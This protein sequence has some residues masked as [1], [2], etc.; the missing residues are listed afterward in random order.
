MQQHICKNCEHVF[1]GNF[2]NHCGQKSKT[3]RLNFHYL[4]DEIKYTFLHI[5]KGLLYSVK[6]LIVRPGDTVREFLEGKRVSHYKPILLLVVLAGISGLLAHYFLDFSEI[7]KNSQ[8][9]VV[10][11]D[12]Q[13]VDF[14]KKIMDWIMEHYSLYEI[15][16]LPLVSL[17]SYLA[18]K[19]YGYNYIENIIINSFAAS[20]RL[21]YGLLIFPLEYFAIKFNFF[22]L[23]S[24]LSLVF[25]I[26]ISIWFYIK[27][28]KD[29]V[30]GDVIVRLLLFGF[31]AF[32]FFSILVAFVFFYAMYNSQLGVH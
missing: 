6:Q 29:K 31:L 18:F 19:K 27:L 14:T 7:Y 9:I 16:Q 4:Q 26:L 30:I 23:Y 22:A 15:I 17:A 2:C 3:E 20:Q 8:A 28:F 21:I 25:I 24:I 12:G 10:N 13:K 11:T 32:M 1:E 5:N